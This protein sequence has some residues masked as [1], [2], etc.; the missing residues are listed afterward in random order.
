MTSFP[1]LH[2]NQKWVIE[3]L[4]NLPQSQWHTFSLYINL[5]FT[6]YQ[7][8]V[9][10]CDKCFTYVIFKTHYNWAREAIYIVSPIYRW[11]TKLKK[12]TFHTASKW[13]SRYWNL[14]LPECALS[15]FSYV[16][17]FLISLLYY[18]LFIYNVLNGYAC[19]ILAKQIFYHSTSKSTPLH[20]VPLKIRYKDMHPM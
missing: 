15:I 12:L 3:I 19:Q 16:H 14:N 9:R 20:T 1:K 8:Y 6:E 11:A 2:I 17:Y 13:H 7:L 10:H 18:V 5:L 4:K